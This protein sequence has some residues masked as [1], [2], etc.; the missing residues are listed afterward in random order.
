LFIPSGKEKGEPGRGGNPGVGRAEELIAIVERNVTDTGAVIV[1]QRD[2]VA[3]LM[4]QA[5]EGPF[6]GEGESPGVALIRPGEIA[7]VLNDAR[8][9]VVG[10]LDQETVVG[11]AGGGG[12]SSEE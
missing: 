1:L 8:I 12:L 7:D 11:D 2:A 6:L 3:E 4:M 10:F 9:L 5:A